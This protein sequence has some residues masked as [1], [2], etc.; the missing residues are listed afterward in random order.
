MLL[1]YRFLY[2]QAGKVHFG[3]V[4]GI[5]L[6]GCVGM[7][8]LLNLMNVTGIPFLLTVSILG[9]SLLPIVSLAMFAVF[10]SLK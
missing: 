1:S 7:F 5:G 10:V 4:Y 3:Y 9:Y 2:V 6:L 8:A